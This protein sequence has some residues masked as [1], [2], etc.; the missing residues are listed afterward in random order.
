MFN[1][2]PCSCSRIDFSSYPN[3]RIALQNTATHA[4]RIPDTPSESENNTL[5]GTFITID[6]RKV[7]AFRDVTSRSTCLGRNQC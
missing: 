2:H 6:M 4:S 7:G 1:H 5:R 3:N